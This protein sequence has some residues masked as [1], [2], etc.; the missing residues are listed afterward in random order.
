MFHKKVI[1][2]LSLSLMACNPG[3]APTTTKTL[4]LEPGFRISAEPVSEPDPE[5]LF[6]DYPE[7]TPPESYKLVYRRHFQIQGQKFTAAK[8]MDKNHSLSIQVVDATGR[9]YEYKELMALS[10]AELAGQKI[11]PELQAVLDLSPDTSI[12]VMLWLNT[13]K[14]EQVQTPTAG[15]GDALLA[16]LKAEQKSLLEPFQAAKQ[17]IMAELSF[18]DEEAIANLPDSPAVLAQLS[19]ARIHALA[20]S[21]QVQMLLLDLPEDEPSLAN[22]LNLS[23]AGEA[24]VLYGSN[25]GQGVRL[26][27]WESGCPRKDKVPLAKIQRGKITLIGGPIWNA[28]DPLPDKWQGDNSAQGKLQEHATHVASLIANFSSLSGMAP[29]VELL[30]AN[31]KLAPNGLD[32]LNWAMQQDA[33][34]INQSFQK[35]FFLSF[36]DNG[37]PEFGK[38][39]ADF[40]HLSPHDLYKD[41]KIL[42][43]PF[44][45]ILQGAGNDGLASRKF[46]GHKG[47][48][49]LS[50]GATNAQQNQMAY[51]SSMRNPASL[52]GDRE[53]PEMVTSGV[54][55]LND[56]HFEGTSFASPLVAGAAALLQGEHSLLKIWPEAV[57]AL[58]L[59]GA[60]RNIPTHPAVTSELAYLNSESGPAINP[61][62]ASGTWWADLLAHKDG[63]D[64]AGALNV[65]ESLQV[66]Q[67]RW[68][69]SPSLEGWD[70]GEINDDSFDARHI[71]STS[72]QIPTLTSASDIRVALAWDNPLPNE[73]KAITDQ[74]GI[75]AL[76]SIHAMPLFY[77]LDVIVEDQDGNLVSESLS[78]DNSYEI[79]DFRG[80]VGNSYTIRVQRAG[81]LKLRDTSVK[82]G[83]AW[84][85]FNITEG[86]PIVNNPSYPAEYPNALAFSTPQGTYKIKPD[87]S[88]ERIVSEQAYRQVAWAPR[89][90]KMAVIK[91]RA[92]HRLELG[93]LQM[94]E[95]TS[96]YTTL[97]AADA[98]VQNSMIEIR[99]TH[100]Q[101]SADGKWLAFVGLKD[102]HQYLF[103]TLADG[104]M[105]SSFGQA[106]RRLSNTYGVG[107]YPYFNAGNSI[108]GSHFFQWDVDSQ[109]LI[110]SE[111][112]DI[113][114]IAIDN[115]SPELLLKMAASEFSLSP[116]GTRLVFLADNSES[117]KQYQRDSG[118]IDTLLSQTDM[119]LAPGDFAAPRWSPDGQKIALEYKLYESSTGR[120]F[121]DLY[122]IE[123]GLSHV[124]ETTWQRLN[125]QPF[126]RV[127]SYVW[128]PDSAQIAASA[129]GMEDRAPLQILIF[130]SVHGPFPVF[131][132]SHLKY[133]LDWSS[134]VP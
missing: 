109:H 7:L 1:L 41:F 113:F 18:S 62:M 98:V 81:G 25:F 80:E 61:N 20:A 39:E 105:Q 44:S 28:C 55:D 4:N 30:S 121:H 67:E 36:D 103:V 83:I 108:E 21:D 79:V 90:D 85:R 38:Y 68:N 14:L 3:S 76:M 65:K 99:D 123:P 116:D 82:F 58:L 66:A 107:E 84:N 26:A 15:D 35:R 115:A 71:L 33:T 94:G 119:G 40:K 29:H 88:E 125:R 59:A 13:P 134:D 37:W 133:S 49:S 111:N 69:G 48:N 52:H 11:D 87:G 129:L 77:D 86:A 34:V 70:I 117:L 24:Q 22:A 114:S 97:V 10:T 46:V 45:S 17:K 42:F 72:Y 63:F 110:Y 100:P 53:L 8:L 6:R 106:A 50:I 124:S 91:E 95:P 56:E 73:L 118:R 132:G 96:H 54:I 104:S 47:F 126:L 64:G 74:Y 19:A 43:P 32:G 23:E 57:R 75:M 12:P 2:A 128:S 60:I 51:F 92:D 102:S 27:I 101:W 122:S 127:W 5:V 78:F 131:E 130:D 89:G 93:V 31:A 112:Q 9:R 16:G 120:Y